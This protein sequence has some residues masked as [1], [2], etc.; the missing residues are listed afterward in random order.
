MSSFNEAT[1]KNGNLTSSNDET[2]NNTFKKRKV[3]LKTKGKKEQTSETVSRDGIPKDLTETSNP[4]A[5]G[6][7]KKGHLSGDEDTDGTAQ[8][9]IHSKNQISMGATTTS[10]AADNTHDL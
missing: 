6:N 2:E 7:S 10:L 5:T 3:D 4:G 8:M 9:N 1:G